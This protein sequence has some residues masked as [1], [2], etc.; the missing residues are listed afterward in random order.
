MQHLLTCKHQQKK[1]DLSV[2]LSSLWLLAER[3]EKK[4]KTRKLGHPTSELWNWS[5]LTDQSSV[6]Y[7]QLVVWDQG[8]RDRTLKK[9]SIQ[10]CPEVKGPKLLSVASVQRLP[11][12]AH[13]ASL[14]ATHFSGFCVTSVTVTAT[15]HLNTSVRPTLSALDKSE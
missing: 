5:W 8:W 15:A 13:P 4:K 6:F 2:Q 12:Q 11:L 9:T 1:E 10:T 7:L 14:W 3:A